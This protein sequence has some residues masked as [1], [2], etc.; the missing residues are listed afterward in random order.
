MLDWRGVSHDRR[1]C[2]S[3]CDARQLERDPRRGALQD[4]ARHRRRRRA[5]T[6]TI[7]GRGATV[8]NLCAN[9]YL[10]LADHPEVVPPR[11]RRST[12]GATGWR[13]VRFICGTQQ[14]HKQLE[15]RLTEFLGTEDTI[16][17]SSCF[18]ANGGLFETLLGAEDAMIT[19]E[20][21]HASI[22][23]GIRLCKAQR[24]RYANSDMAD[25]EA[26]LR[27]ARR[28]ARFRTDRDRRRVLD[29]RL[30]RRTCRRSAIWPKIR[31]A[32]DGRRLARRRLHGQTGPRHAR[33]P[34][35]RWAAS[36]SSPAR[37]ARR[38]AARAAATRPRGRRSSSCCAS[39][40]GRICSRTARAG[41][42][43]R[44]R[45]QALELLVRDR[46]SCA[47]GWSEHGVLPRG[48][49]RDPARTFCPAST[50]SC[51]SCSATRAARTGRRRGLREGYLRRRLLLSGRPARQGPHPHAGL[52]GPQRG[53]PAIRRRDAR[54]C[55]GG[56]IDL[57]PRPRAVETTR[58][59]SSY[60]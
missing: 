37:S 10:G 24:F 53:R 18:D 15:T 2:G 12:P 50:R 36:I 1:R 55:R 11:T 31:R 58:R 56:A 46:P 47:T 26:K 4:R 30:H 43:G 7:A 19:D 17:Y 8:L 21:N 32:G 6:S 5:R 29:G 25:L 59:R 44:R 3:S 20:L 23:D 60:G 40:R 51:R 39:A 57:S 28:S 13:R 9:N 38:S 16:L 33:A 48:D 49:R 22:I 14:L 41:D 35:R 54:E 52:G 34:R 45:S 27:E 42:R